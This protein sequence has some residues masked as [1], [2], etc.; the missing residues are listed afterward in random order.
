MTHWKYSNGWNGIRP[1][2]FG[3]AGVGAVLVWVLLHLGFCGTASADAGHAGQAGAFL[4][5]GLGARALAMGGG[6]GALADDAT[7]AY[8]NPAGLVFLEGRRAGLSLDA[9]ALD[10]KLMSAGYAQPF[11]SRPD[12]GRTGGPMRAGFSLCW[13]GAVTDRI[14]GRDWDGNHTEMLTHVENA[15]AFSFA[16][17]PGPAV[18]I[19]FTAK[20]LWSV[21]PGL[22]DRNES[23]G[24]TGVGFD[25]GVRIRPV[26]SF[27]FAFSAHDIHSRYTWDSQKMYERGSQTV[28][29][30]P[31][32]IRA[33]AAWTGW[34]DRLT[35]VAQIEQR[36]VTDAEPA[37]WLPVEA[38]LGMECQPS[39]GLFLRAGVNREGVPFGFGIRRAL[40]GRTTALD[41]AYVPESVAP[42]GRHA[43]TWSFFF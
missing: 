29:P 34:A 16:L 42:R 8:G 5:M 22:T 9:M 4:R 10:R 23:M 14:D 30:F 6:T 24:A 11:G 35:A 17:Q 19:G 36:K 43:F 18:G 25:A 41:Y 2:S 37:R 31:L 32:G 21:F 28:S 12:S 3:P 7:T 27:A 38:S 15:F 1:S 13:I 40:L 39:A 33:S 26:R 20:V